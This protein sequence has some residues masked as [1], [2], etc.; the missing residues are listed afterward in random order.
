MDTPISRAE[1]LEFVRRMETENKRLSDED[2][3]QNQR[4]SELEENVHQIGELTMSVARLA[5]SMESMVKEQEEQGNRLK[6]LEER[7]GEMWRKV[8]GYI[9]TAI[10]GIVIGFIFTQMGI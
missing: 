3:R 4:I 7:D 1:H 9:I 5:T 10:A 8:T 6:T 2:N